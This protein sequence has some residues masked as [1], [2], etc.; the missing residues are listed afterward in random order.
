MKI[1]DIFKNID[2][3]NSQSINENEFVLV[4]NKLN[5]NLSVEK[6]KNIFHSC[7]LINNGLN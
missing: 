7:N 5:L 4:I 6:I 1:K 3:D 2:R